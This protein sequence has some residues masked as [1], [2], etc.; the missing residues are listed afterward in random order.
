[1]SIPFDYHSHNRRC[2]HA[3]GEIADYVE[4]AKLLGMTEFGVSDH[5]PTL[6]KDGDDN[7]QGMTMAKSALPGYVAETVE[8]KERYAGE[9]VVKL[10]LETDYVAGF[11]DEYRAL[12]D[13]HPFDYAIG[14]VHW[15]NGVHVFHRPR[16][17]YEDA[18]DTYRQYYGLQVAAARSGMF[19]I[20]AHATAAEA[21]GP[22]LGDLA[23][24]LY[25]PL[26]EA[27]REAGLVVEVNTA[28]FRKMGGEDPFPNRALL[29]LLAD[30]RVPLTFGSDSH[31]PDEV[32]Y[33]QGRV[34]A[35]VRD[36]GYDVE[37]PR[38]VTVRRGPI[39]AFTR[40]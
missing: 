4:A 26:V 19:D 38:P 34:E 18:A 27:V 29:R 36:L 17:E 24:E 2:G 30:A 13:A 21:F 1:M 28:G 6:Y 37:N 20:L 31:R 12:L 39:L 7:A 10:G 25:P 3:A 5:S 14:S 32:G 40:A 9:V 33:D 23:D 22:P 15:V 16:W 8:L 11:E 35:L